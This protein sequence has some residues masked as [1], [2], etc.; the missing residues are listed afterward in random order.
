MKKLFLIS[1]LI[2]AS[3]L[4]IFCVASSAAADVSF[5]TVNITAERVLP[6]NYYEFNILSKI[7]ASEI[8]GNIAVIEH[9][10]DQNYLRIIGNDQRKKSISEG[11]SKI[12]AYGDYV[13]GN[14][15]GEYL[16]TY[17]VTDDAFN[18][19]AVT[20]SVYDIA[21]DEAENKLYI[22]TN[23]KLI[24]YDLVAATTLN[25]AYCNE[26]VFPAD[27]TFVY[28]NRII[29]SEGTIYMYHTNAIKVY[30]FTPLESEINEVFSGLISNNALNTLFYPLESDF[31]LIKSD[32]IYLNGYAQKVIDVSGISVDNELSSLKAIAVSDN[33]IYIIDNDYNAIKVFS[34]E[35]FSYLHYY[36]SYGK[37][38]LRLNSPTG[39]FVTENGNYIADTGNNRVM[40]YQYSQEAIAAVSLYGSVPAYPKFLASNSS[41]LYVSN[42][43]NHIFYYESNTYTNTFSLD[44][45]VTGMAI[46]EN[47]SV[48]VASGNKIYI[49]TDNDTTFTPYIETP[50]AIKLIAT[51]MNGKILYVVDNSTIKGYCGN[52]LIEAEISLADYSID[53]QEI[54]GLTADYCG[55][56]FLTTANSIMQFERKPTDYE[57]CRLY[58]ITNI[59]IISGIASSK[60]GEIFIT[61]SNSLLKVDD[62]DMLNEDN[63]IIANPS[64]I[65]FPIKLVKG[66]GWVQS[67]LNN[68][69]DIVFIDEE[70]YL[71]VFNSGIEYKQVEYYYVEYDNRS[72]YIPADNCNIIQN[73]PLDEKY[74]TCL[75]DTVNIYQYP[76]P[77]SSAIF[78]GL[79]RDNVIEV[80]AYV[81]Y[82]NDEDVWGWYEVV[83]EGRLGYVQISSVVDAESPYIAVERYYVKAKSAHFGATIKVYAE[84]TKE[85][86][87]IANLSDGT[88][89]EL[90]APYSENTEFSEV[91]INGTTG[92]ILTDNLMEKGLTNG[93]ILA[94]VLCVVTITAS[95]VS[96]LL[97]KLFKKK[98][99]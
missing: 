80:N 21:I 1:L 9:D 47:N 15:G 85:A 65:E 29:A 5:E 78:T 72:V 28:P 60:E 46:L 13:I 56:L 23:T 48:C 66:N 11:V 30:S 36:G 20:S 22:L 63:S 44:S 19:T 2:M 17:S 90:T 6:D 43:D 42:G 33:K 70:E 41:G 26:Y 8:S 69:E 31:L 99:K 96:I 82:Y 75:F 58:N 35:D 32:G 91:R 86:E 92:Y 95:A 52:R 93:Q 61:S 94:I 4:M 67:S 59:A 64:V 53:A 81:A 57:F 68:Y 39:I 97:F 24:W 98:V 84:A 83:Y 7:T 79:T 38:D 55:N 76:S 62:V 45:D 51:G 3:F 10:N 40:S 89:V 73:G 50:S 14:F 37:G 34:T 12:C 54:S 74:V 77:T 18:V 27:D 88:T 87:I 49:K 16:S 25:I 71:M